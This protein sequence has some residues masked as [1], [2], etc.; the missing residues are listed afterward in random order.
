MHR[1][2]SVM[3]I[4]QVKMEATQGHIDAEK[5]MA[6]MNRQ[7]LARHRSKAQK[8]VDRRRLMQTAMASGK[9]KIEK[10]NQELNR[11]VDKY[12]NT[13]PDESSDSNSDTD[14][15]SS[16][17]NDGPVTPKKSSFRRTSTPKVTNADDLI[18]AAMPD[19]AAYAMLLNGPPTDGKWLLRQKGQK[20]RFSKSKL[21]AEEWILDVLVG[22]NVQS[23]RL[24]KNVDML[25]EIGINNTMQS[26]LYDVIGTDSTFHLWPL[27]SLGASYEL[28]CTLL[29]HFLSYGRQSGAKTAELVSNNAMGMRMCTCSSLPRLHFYGRGFSPS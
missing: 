20:A 14:D 4:K 25:Y 28:K 3:K 24:T 15:G 18:Y 9:A 16:W 7:T 23:F 5:R 21:P 29:P 13:I 12:S 1:K 10:K 22:E 27:T 26:S 11:I 17:K 8:V 19:E 2:Q 6:E